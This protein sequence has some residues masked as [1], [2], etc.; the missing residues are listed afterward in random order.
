MRNIHILLT[1]FIFVISACTDHKYSQ[2]L[3][4]ADS[5]CHT[6]PDSA[7]SLLMK[8]G[9][10]T[11]GT[12]KETRIY[13]RLLCIQANDRTDNMKPENEKDNITAIADYY[14]QKNDK[15]LLP[16]A[17]YYAGRI[18]A[19]LQDAPQALDYF[20]KADD[21]LKDEENIDLHSRIYS[22]LG[23]LFYYQEM[24][25]VSLEMF[26]NAYKCNKETNDTIAMIYDL[27]DI[28]TSYE[29]KKEHGKA[30]KYL[31]DAYHLARKYKNKY[32]ITN[33][34]HYT[35]SLYK[36][37]NKPDSA[38]KYAQ[39]SLE[40]ISI[41]DSSSTYSLIAD[42]YKL[43][44][45]EDS[46]L[47]YCKKIEHV[48]NVYAKD[49]AYENLTEIY[50]N[51]GN[52]AEAKRCFK[53][54]GIYADSVKVIKRTDVIAR[55]NAL[56]NYQAKEK[57]NTLLQEKSK[58]N[59]ITIIFSSTIALISLTYLLI[60]IRYSKNKRK[61]QLQNYRMSKE[62]LNKQLCSF[63]KHINRNRQTIAQLENKLNDLNKEN[64]ELKKELEREKERLFTQ[65]SI[66]AIGIKK[67]DNTPETIKNS[68]IYRAF[69][70][71][72]DKSSHKKPTAED[73]DELEKLLN[74]EYSNF[75][76]K[77]NSL[78]KLSEIEY[79]VSMLIKINFEPSRI[80]ELVC[81]SLSNISTIRS[82]LYIKAFGRKAKTIAWDEFLHSL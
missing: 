19:E 53:M 18:Y 26:I 13:Y 55:M 43:K 71:M 16:I 29:A 23:Y 70:R 37:L 28:S 66:A 27:R 80:A 48:G 73:W 5:L 72:A 47:Y 68:P 11:A 79:H 51:R 10:D 42:V 64:T 57:E 30:L 6:N 34:E 81:C 24:Y 31:K 4:Q 58:R 35:S 17:Y 41:M 39:I 32:M 40:N 46:L 20:K 82:R 3:I 76:D 65:D 14:K 56:Y 44:R 67:Q 69:Y 62:I 63:E 7:V 54:H 78:Y 36:T 22:Q 52:H 12:P 2:Y 33:I 59:K 38:L 9:K 60:Y 74:R 50:L 61:V 25:D 21:A 75:S 49:F 8:I 15:Y 1:F 77:L 45:N